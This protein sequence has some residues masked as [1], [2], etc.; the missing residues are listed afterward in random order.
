MINSVP[1]RLF[2]RDHSHHA[3]HLDNR[4]GNFGGPLIDGDRE[5]V[6]VVFAIESAT[7][8]G[9][10]VPA[11]ALRDA[12]STRDFLRQIRHPADPR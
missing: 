9:L 7:G 2:K 10:I 5:V 6:G 1:G 4:P 12:M 3:G 11:G 8:H